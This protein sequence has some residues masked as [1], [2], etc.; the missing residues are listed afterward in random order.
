MKE[1]FPLLINPL[2]LGVMLPLH[3]HYN[4]ECVAVSPE[5][6]NALGSV[7]LTLITNIEV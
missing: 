1:V 3:Y 2:Q 7:S 4:L 6:K 5:G